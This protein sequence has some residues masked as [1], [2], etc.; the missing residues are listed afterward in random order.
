VN[1]SFAGHLNLAARG[2]MVADVF[3]RRY[4]AVSQRSLLLNKVRKG[5]ELFQQLGR[6]V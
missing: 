3:K 6:Q 4:A 5:G 2:G 1:T